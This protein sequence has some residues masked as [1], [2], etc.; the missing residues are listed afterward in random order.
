MRG[1]HPPPAGEAQR[2][3]HSLLPLHGIRAKH[4]CGGAPSHLQTQSEAQW[5]RPRRWRCPAGRGGA[6][7]SHFCTGPQADQRFDEPP[8]I[9]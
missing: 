2:V 5:P 6:S 4:V 9:C 8:G 7:Q 3:R 1:D